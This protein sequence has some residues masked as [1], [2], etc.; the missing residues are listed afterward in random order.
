MVNLVTNAHA[1]NQPATNIFIAIS[2][3]RGRILTDLFGPLLHV[4]FFCL[5]YT[6]MII[7]FSLPPIQTFIE[8]G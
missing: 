2:G 3:I 5:V 6:N 8:T 7:F 1:Y 4:L